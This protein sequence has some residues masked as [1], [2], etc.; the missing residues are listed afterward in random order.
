MSGVESISKI[1]IV[2]MNIGH[3]NE[4]IDPL[5]SVYMKPHKT[6]FRIDDIKFVKLEK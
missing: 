5:F 2:L 4:H 3:F 6:G 1:I